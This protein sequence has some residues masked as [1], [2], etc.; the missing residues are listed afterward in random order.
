MIRHVLKLGFL[1]LVGI[2]GYNFFFGSVSEKE[3]SRKIFGQVK[4]VAV[5]IKDLAKNEK[6]KFNAGKYDK[7]LQKLGGAY[8]GLRERLGNVDKKLLKKIDELDE[9]KSKLQQEVRKMDKDGDAEGKKDLLDKIQQLTEDT[10]KI[11]EHLPK[12]SE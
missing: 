1:L 10:Q 3:N 6:A 2:L 8:K 12:D 4:E 5:S 11:L 7:A 9:R